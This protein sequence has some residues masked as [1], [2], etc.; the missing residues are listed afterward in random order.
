[1]SPSIPPH[2][3]GG[4]DPVAC[5]D[6]RVHRRPSKRVLKTTMTDCPDCGNPINPSDVMCRNSHFVGYPNHRVALEERDA[7]LERYETARRDC[8]TRSLDTLLDGLEAIAERSQ[9]LIAMSFEA[10]D[11]VFRSKKYLNYSQ[12]VNANLRTPARPVDHADRAS[13][14]PQRYRDNRGPFNRDGHAYH[15]GRK[16]TDGRMGSQKLFNL[17]AAGN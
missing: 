2:D 7:L 8:E 13:D 10:S 17:D 4:R 1:M 12:S 3:L 5:L 9:P 11:S 14:V 6:L 15:H 16:D